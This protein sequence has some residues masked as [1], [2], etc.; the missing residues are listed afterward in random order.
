MILRYVFDF[1]SPYAWVAWRPVRALAERHGRELA[2]E[3][4]LFAALLDA[5]GNVGP[6]EVPAKRAYIFKDAYRKAHARGLPPLVLPPAHPFNPLA[7]LR[8]VTAV[9]SVALVDALFASAWVDGRAIDTPD[10]VAAVAS[11]IGLDGSDVVR[12]ATSV[13][14][15]DRLRQVTE[16]AAQ[17]GVFGVPT[18]EVDGELFWGSDAIEH[19]D[20]HLRGEDPLPRDP[21]YFDR[22]RG[23][24]RPA[25]G[26]K[27]VD[28]AA[29]A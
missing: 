29:G 6:A 24:D 19:A 14:T 1:V 9:P 10:A 22:P 16:A 27:K 4:V 8:A 28:P 2:L 5:H 11:S 13:A 21:A 7:A 17:R 26:A 25:R 15:K 23:A 12:R 20:A 3:P 18:I